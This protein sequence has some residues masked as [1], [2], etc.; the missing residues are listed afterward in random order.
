MILVEFTFVNKETNVVTTHQVCCQTETQIIGA[1]DYIVNKH[2]LDMNEYSQVTYITK[3]C[4][5]VSPQELIA[6]ENANVHSLKWNGSTF[7]HKQPPRHQKVIVDNVEYIVDRKQLRLLLN[8]AIDKNNLSAPK[9]ES[10][11]VITLNGQ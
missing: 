3:D 11:V 4:D 10:N 1:L 5:Y 6:L 9:I 8:N 2:E 7:E